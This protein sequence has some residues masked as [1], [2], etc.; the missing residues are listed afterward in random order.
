MRKTLE[1]Q[2]LW[3]KTS[4]KESETSY[5][6]KIVSKDIDSQKIWDKL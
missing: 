3:T 1:L 6:K 5:K 2:K 4:L